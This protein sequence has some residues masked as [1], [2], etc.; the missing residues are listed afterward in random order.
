MTAGR[1][2]RSGAP[3]AGRTPTRSPQMSP[4]EL[5]PMRCAAGRRRQPAPAQSGRA[6]RARV[7]ASHSCAPGG[8]RPR[9]SEADSPA[10]HLDAVHLSQSSRSSVDAAPDAWGPACTAV[11]SKRRH[12]LGPSHGRHGRLGASWPSAREALGGGVRPALVGVGRLGGAST[13]LSFFRR[14]ATSLF[15]DSAPFFVSCAGG[16]HSLSFV[17]LATQRLAPGSPP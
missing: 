5:A 14:L 2:A 3:D 10:Y 15:N 17:R 7:M 4:R 6:S 8:R 16:F 13:V 11:P 12:R 9:P 1:R